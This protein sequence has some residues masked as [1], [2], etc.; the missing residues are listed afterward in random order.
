MSDLNDHTVLI[1]PLVDG[2]WK[3]RQGSDSAQSHHESQH[4]SGHS[5]R[6]IRRGSDPTDSDPKNQQ[7]RKYRP[8]QALHH[9]FPPF[10]VIWFQFPK[11]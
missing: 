10:V 5:D 11:T 1:P 3:S 8:N 9:G 6:W 7:K 2:E 4:S